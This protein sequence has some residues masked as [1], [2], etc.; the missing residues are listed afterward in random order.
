MPGLTVT[1][2]SKFRIQMGETVIL[3]LESH[4]GAAQ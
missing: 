4:R 2:L 1:L 3:E